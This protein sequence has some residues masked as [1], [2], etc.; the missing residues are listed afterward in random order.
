MRVSNMAKFAFWVTV[1]SKLGKEH[2]VEE[3]LKSAR[4]MAEMEP[5]TLTWYAVKLGQSKYAIFDSFADEGGRKAHL[6]GKIAQA[7][8]GLGRELL[9]KD[10][11]VHKLDVL[12][13]KTMDVMKLQGKAHGT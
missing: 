9:A 11:E 3:F 13:A 7:L 5:G 6:T 2:E 4:A 8:F 10:P 1:E 12:A